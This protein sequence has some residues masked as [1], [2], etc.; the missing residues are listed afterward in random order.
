MTSK[1]ERKDYEDAFHAKVCPKPQLPP[2]CLPAGPDSEVPPLWYGL[3]IPLE[4]VRDYVVKKGNP[5]NKNLTGSPMALLLSAMRLLQEACN[6]K[7][8]FFINPLRP[9]SD[10][11]DWAVVFKCSRWRSAKR[12]DHEADETLADA[13]RKE[14]DLPSDRQPLW[15]FDYV[16]ADEVCKVRS[17]P[18]D[19][20][21][22]TLMY[23]GPL[24]LQLPPLLETGHLGRPP[25]L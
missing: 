3:P 24:A 2:E 17:V 1:Q 19:S 14:M 10:E 13:I 7:R 6:N 8:I 21:E 22:R 16:H 23:I 4:A 18:S 20:R 15:H 5:D 9:Y 25:R 12:P 11:L